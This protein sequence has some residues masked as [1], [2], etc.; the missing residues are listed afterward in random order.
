MPEDN[1]QAEPVQVDVHQQHLV[2]IFRHD[3][4]KPFPI[5]HIP[6]EIPV[7]AAQSLVTVAIIYPPL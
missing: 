7:P 1:A 5:I 2:N 6:N 4:N 3:N